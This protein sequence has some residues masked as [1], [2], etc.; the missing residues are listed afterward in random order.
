MTSKQGI[1]IKP[2]V[3]QDVRAALALAELP[4]VTW[5][6]GDDQ[7]DCI[8]QRIG[9]WTNPYLGGTLQVRLCCI[10]A[11]LYEEFPEF[12]RVI[13]ASF[14]GNRH[15]WVREPQPW[16]SEEMDMPVSLWYRQL[17][18]QTGKSIADIRLEYRNRIAERPKKVPRGKGWE[19]RP[20]PTEGEV[21][22]AHEARLR[23]AT[24]IV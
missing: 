14:D 5:C 19:S 15:K 16:D 13:P 8:F 23:A 4:D 6:D 1:T 12:V 3:L 17:A 18:A 10:W 24:W 11:K 21:K 22:A 7:C 9:E 2:Q 20:Q